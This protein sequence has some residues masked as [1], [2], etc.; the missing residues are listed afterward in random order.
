MSPSGRL[1]LWLSALLLGLS[2]LLMGLVALARGHAAARSAVN[3]IV[4]REQD[5]PAKL[6]GG[7]RLPKGA[8]LQLKAGRS[9]RWA[10]LLERSVLGDR[11][12]KAVKRLRSGQPAWILKG[13]GAPAS[14]AWPQLANARRELKLVATGYDPGPV[15]NTRGWVGSTRTGAR[16]HFG[17]VAVDPHVVP[18]GSLVYV[19]GY[20]PGLAADV[21][22][23]IKGKR[24]DLCFNSSQEARAWGRRPTRVWIVER[25]PKTAR[26]AYA[27]KSA[28]HS[29]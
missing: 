20:G 21:G 25:V 22:G 17:I 2:P 10:V 24:I 15:D 13:T 8:L 4:E 12:L 18:L 29:E 26:L 11:P 1:G 23:A 19:E 6:S 7:P 28:S 3:L 16:A 9:E 14:I 5:P 27:I